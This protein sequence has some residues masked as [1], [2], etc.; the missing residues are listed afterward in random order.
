M[1]KK[2][3]AILLASTMTLAFTACGSSDDGAST[4]G[5]SGE[6]ASEDT[7][8][9]SSSSDEGGSFEG[10]SIEIDIE[11]SIQGDPE[12][13]DQF[14]KEI[15]AFCE[16]TGAEIEVVQNG[17]DQENILKTRMASQDMPDMF[18]THG[19]AALRYNDFC[20]DLSGEEWI[21]RVDESVLSVITD[22]DGKVCTAPLTQW[23]YGMVFNKDVMD[24]N[25][26]DPYAFKTWDD[27][28]AACE[29]LK[30]NG[31]TPCAVAGKNGGGLPGLMEAANVFYSADGAAY[32]NQ[33]ALLDGTFDWTQNTQFWDTYAQ[34]YDNGWFNEDIFTADSTTV[35]KYMGTG[36]YGFMLWCGVS[37]MATIKSYTP[38]AN[39]G[40][41]PIPA[42]EEGGNAAYTVG[43]GTCI[44]ISNTSENIE[45]CKA[46][47]DYLLDKDNLTEYCNVNGGMPGLTDITPEESES[48][49][50]YQNSVESAG[51]NL[52]FTNFF[53]REYLPS[54]MWNVMQESMATLFNG[55]VGTA[56]DRVP[57]VAQYFQDNYETLYETNA[58]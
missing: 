20:E 17:G 6:T 24:A 21:S 57:E 26:I 1:K 49:T 3:L 37:D 28:F 14:L 33:E 16:E 50:L 40:I 36:E 13:L 46:V 11:D 4:S 41:I 44:A 25:G 30:A 39:L 12:T 15:D 19:W 2:V 34:I 18:V 31:I 56:K 38:D 35:Q 51:D 8:G 53:D 23:V 45:L 42:V 54:G 52:V 55:D 58:G 29:T 7:D 43:E 10:A 9:D 48:L 27:V 47:L 5:D 32:Q 22:A